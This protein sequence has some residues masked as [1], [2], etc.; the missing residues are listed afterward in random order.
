[1]QWKKLGRIFD[2]TKHKLPGSCREFAQSPQTLIFD[3]F[4]RIYFSTR[5]IDNNGKYLS[6]IAYVDMSKDL[7][8][9]LDLSQ[10]QVIELGELGCFDEHGIFPI[11]I[12]RNQD[13]IMAYTCGWSRRTSV[14]VETG[15]GLAISNDEGRTFT[16]IGN[17]PILSSSLHEPFLVGDPF[18]KY[19]EGQFHMWYMFGKDWFKHSKNAPADRIY[20]IGHATSEDGQNWKRAGGRQ[21]ISDHLNC[22]ESMALPTVTKINNR[23]H[24]LFCFRESYDFRKNNSRSYRIGYAYSDDLLNW[25]RDD[26]KAGISTSGQ[27]WDSGMLCYPH[28]FNINGQ[29]FVLYNGND[30][31]RYGFGAALLE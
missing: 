27:G 10:H 17:G 8:K 1:M 6:H 9:I 18:V 5:A 21:I 30:F 12:I 15:I 22:N 11:N 14:S 25:T 26:S 28:L 13:K 7:K 31:G 19:Y 20:K 2:P 16:K 23:Y 3:N 4:V 24:M 29:T